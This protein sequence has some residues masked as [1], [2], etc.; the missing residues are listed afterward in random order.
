MKLLLTQHAKEQMAARGITLEQI[1]LAIQ[2]GST[3]KQTGGYLSSYTYIMVAWKKLD[4]YY[5]I[6]T[7]MVK[8]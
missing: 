5:K 4:E 7:V 8:E 6:K 3:I 2:R 1:R